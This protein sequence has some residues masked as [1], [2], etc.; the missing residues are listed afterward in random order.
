M[1]II[2]PN[3][4]NEAVLYF[5]NE[6][7]QT[8]QTAYN[9]IAKDTPYVFLT[10]INHIDI[11]MLNS[12][13]YNFNSQLGVEINIGK[14]KEIWLTHYRTARTPLLAK[15]DI[16]FMKAIESGNTVLQAEIAA[17][18]Q[19][20]RDVTLTQLPD[21]LEEIKSTWPEILKQNPF[22]IS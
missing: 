2:F 15:L 12:G 21:T 13:A 5:I 19:A 10:D 1:Y 17:K 20:L 7:E 6:I 9:H 18:K 16:D 14:V 22:S 11:Y 8:K 3:K 4:S